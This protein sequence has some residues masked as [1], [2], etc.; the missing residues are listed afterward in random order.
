MHIHSLGLPAVFLVGGITRNT[1]PFAIRLCSGDALLMA[2]PCRRA[3]H[4]QSMNL[5]VAF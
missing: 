4:G 1:P 3:F 5:I 2:G